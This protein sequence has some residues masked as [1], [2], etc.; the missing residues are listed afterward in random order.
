MAYYLED[1]GLFGQ[2]MYFWVEKTS[3]CFCPWCDDLEVDADNNN[4][5]DD[6]DLKGRRYK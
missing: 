1:F 2:S 3:R 6:G 4:D 5:R